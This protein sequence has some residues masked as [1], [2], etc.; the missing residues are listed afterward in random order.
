MV[1]LI[2]KCRIVSARSTCYYCCRGACLLVLLDDSPNAILIDARTVGRVIGGSRATQRLMVWTA[3]RRRCSGEPTHS[4]RR[5][6]WRGRP[7]WLSAFQTTPS[8]I[9]ASM[10]HVHELTRL[11]IA[12]QN[13]LNE[14]ALR[15]S[16]EPLRAEETEL[17][18]HSCTRGVRCSRT[19]AQSALPGP[20]TLVMSL[21]CNR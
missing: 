16:G 11:G 14:A 4:A 12:T 21:W 3:V 7:P 13:G 9:S 19:G 2:V 6:S 1:N 18:Q 10:S 15:A 17:L 20:W 8:A 5:P